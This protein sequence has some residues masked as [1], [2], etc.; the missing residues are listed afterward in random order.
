MSQLNPSALYVPVMGRGQSKALGSADA[1]SS[2]ARAAGSSPASPPP[3]ALAGKHPA[4]LQGNGARPVRFSFAQQVKPSTGGR[5]LEAR[6]AVTFQVAPLT[7]ESESESESE[8]EDDASPSP[9][10]SPASTPRASVSGGAHP[11]SFAIGGSAVSR[12]LPDAPD[13]ADP[14]AVAS[15][16]FDRKSG[17]PGAEASREDERA[18]EET[19]GAAV[20]PMG[21]ANPPGTSGV[22]ITKDGRPEKAFMEGLKFAEGQSTI[23]SALLDPKGT[24]KPLGPF[25]A[26]V[27]HG[28]GLGAP[29]SD[30]TSVRALAL[31]VMDMGANQ[32]LSLGEM[33]ECLHAIKWAS[34]GIRGHLDLEAM[35]QTGSKEGHTEEEGWKKNLAMI[36]WSG[37]FAPTSEGK[38]DGI[39]GEATPAPAAAEAETDLEATDPATPP[40]SPSSS[41]SSP[42]AKPAEDLPASPPPSGAP[43]LKA[44]NPERGALHAVPKTDYKAARATIT[45]ALA[46]F[47][48][49]SESEFR[50]FL[51]QIAK[52]SAIEQDQVDSIARELDDL[53][54]RR[55]DAMAVCLQFKR[56]LESRKVALPEKLEIPWSSVAGT[57]GATELKSM[58]DQVAGLRARSLGSPSPAVPRADQVNM[59]FHEVSAKHAQNR[60]AA[61]RQGAPASAHPPGAASP[62]FSHLL[63]FAKDAKA[64]GITNAFDPAPASLIASPI[65]S[66]I[67]P[68]KPG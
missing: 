9:E 22:T 24:Q 49:S 58:K 45:Q 56:E 60:Q 20:G 27:I 42:P 18:D 17:T 50:A 5:P 7:I 52:R 13:E 55:H 10:V 1:A 53:A 3:S 61:G 11:F 26:G 6:A 4:V 68:P 64:L 23:K 16:Q 15:P 37:S 19:P 57:N 14:A 51:D 31:K 65:A 54:N 21:E 38:A 34:T 32:L 25:M 48:G 47:D 29:G 28:M 12:Q 62:N 66:P 8:D 43:D 35:I 30:H 67:S 39:A 63:K 36:S 44:S 2:Q 40:P 33:R 59:A 41:P 46:G